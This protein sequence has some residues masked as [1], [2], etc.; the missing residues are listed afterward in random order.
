[1]TTTSTP[2]VD[3]HAVQLADS[4]VYEEW[5]TF[6][7]VALLPGHH[8]LAVHSRLSTASDPEA[9]NARYRLTLSTDALLRLH[10]C[11]GEYLN[12]LPGD[13]GTDAP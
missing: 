10:R 6:K 13:H 3:K 1:M 9:L 2:G 11:L 12:A 8:E 4:Q 5:L 7:P